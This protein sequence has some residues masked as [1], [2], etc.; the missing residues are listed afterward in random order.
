MVKLVIFDFDDTLFF[1]T[2][3]HAKSYSQA[4]SEL[5]KIYVSDLMIEKE[6]K[7]GAVFPGLLSSFL[8]EISIDLAKEIH[9][10]KSE[11][12]MKS[13]SAIRINNRIIDLLPDVSSKYFTAIWSNSSRVNIEMLL[14]RILESQVG[15]IILSRIDNDG[16]MNGFD[17]EFPRQILNKLTIPLVLSHGA[18]NKQ[19][20]EKALEKGFLNFTASSMFVFIGNLKAV[21]INNP[22]L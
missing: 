7:A 4:I 5:L 19:S 10:R 3:V 18:R 12:Y 15:E 1:T 17:L 8:P 9:R 14:T 20:I 11:I 16:L 21:L 13:S 6:I 2:S 22:L